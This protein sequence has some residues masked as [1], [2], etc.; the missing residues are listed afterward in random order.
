MFSLNLL[1]SKF[2]LFKWKNAFCGRVKGEIPS[3]KVFES[4][5]FLCILGISSVLDMPADLEG[6]LLILK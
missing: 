6:E 1:L 4:D 3:E 5:N 2:V